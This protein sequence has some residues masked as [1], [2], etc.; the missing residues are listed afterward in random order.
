MH[1]YRPGLVCRKCQG[2]QFAVVYTRHRIGG[3]LRSRRCKAC[4]ER[5]ITWERPAGDWK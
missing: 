2:R 1:S 5:M 4:G 3:I